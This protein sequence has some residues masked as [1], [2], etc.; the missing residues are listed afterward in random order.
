MHNSCWNV[1]CLRVSADDGPWGIARHLFNI[2]STTYQSM[3]YPTSRHDF[4]GAALSQLLDSC[5]EA[6]YSSV[7]SLLGADP[8]HRDLLQFDATPVYLPVHST[9]ERTV[10][11]DHTLNQRRR[12]RPFCQLPMEVIQLILAWLPSTDIAQ[13]RLASRAV[14]RVSTIDVLSQAFWSSRFA[15]DFEMGFAMPR[16][17]ELPKIPSWRDLFF[18]V[19][20]ALR[21]EK[22]HLSLKNRKRVWD[23]LGPTSHVLK[24]L[25]KSNGLSGVSITWD[26]HAPLAWPRRS[27]WPRTVLS[28]LGLGQVI[29]GEALSKEISSLMS[30]GCREVEVRSVIWP[31][32]LPHGGCN[33]NIS[34]LSLNHQVYISGIRISYK[35]Y[36]HE[37][38]HEYS[39]GLINPSSEHSISISDTEVLQGFEVAVTA[40]GIVGLRVFIQGLQSRCSAW[41]GET[42]TGGPDIGFGRLLAREGHSIFAVAAGFDVWFSLLN[43]LCG[44]WTASNGYCRHAR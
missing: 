8:D 22:D 26:D 9:L 36:R 23:V 1:L 34:T 20:H 14:S 25:S 13:L 42:G 17:C 4:G 19:K 11:G 16:D 24:L 18:A 10:E 41:V 28:D 40:S 12:E 15:P 6:A 2:L 27:E 5:D 29:T 35:T 43:T 37:I 44:I 30:L 21:S 39:L 7:L 32:A 31:T 38:S 33:I 3:Y